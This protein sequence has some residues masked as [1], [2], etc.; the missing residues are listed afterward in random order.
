MGNHQVMTDY[1]ET[2]GTY[3]IIECRRRLHREWSSYFLLY[4]T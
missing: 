3:E 1:T 4:L 2:I